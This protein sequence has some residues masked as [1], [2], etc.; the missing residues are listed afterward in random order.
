MCGGD[1]FHTP[2]DYL[3]RAFYVHTNGAVLGGETQKKEPREWRG[4]N[5]VW[6]TNDRYGTVVKYLR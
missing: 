4:R 3:L 6:V 2:G 1:H 5:D